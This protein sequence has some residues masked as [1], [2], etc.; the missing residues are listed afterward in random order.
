MD[1]WADPTVFIN[2]FRRL[3]KEFRQVAAPIGTFQPFGAFKGL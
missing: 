1:N 3:N 2:K